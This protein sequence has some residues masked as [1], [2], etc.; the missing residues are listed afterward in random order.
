MYGTY[1]RLHVSV[2]AT[3]REVI[4]A[5]RK[6]TQGAHAGMT[7]RIARDASC[8]TATCLSITPRRVHLV[9]EWRL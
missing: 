7:S 1:Q 6:Q 3:N 5:A 4:K 8:S 9:K 2:H